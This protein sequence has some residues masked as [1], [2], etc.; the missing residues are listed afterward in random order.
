MQRQLSEKTGAGCVFRGGTVLAPGFLLPPAAPLAPR[1][2]GFAP[3]QTERYK[4]YCVPVTVDLK[5]SCTCSCPS[6][7]ALTDGQRLSHY[8]SLN[9]EL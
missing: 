9:H 3:E 5:E 1:T 4:G 6:F 7:V 8:Y 2:G